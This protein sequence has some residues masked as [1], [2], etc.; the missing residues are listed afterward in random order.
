MWKKI[1]RATKNITYIAADN[2]PIQ[3]SMLMMKNTE[4]VL[5]AMKPLPPPP[6][7]NSPPFTER[8]VHPHTKLRPYL[9]VSGRRGGGWM[10]CIFLTCVFTFC[11]PPWNIRFHRTRVNANMSHV[12]E[13]LLG[14]DQ[15]HKVLRPMAP[16]V[17][18]YFSE[19]IFTSEVVWRGMRRQNNYTTGNGNSDRESDCGQ[20]YTARWYNLIITESQVN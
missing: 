18:D 6:P 7:L 9:I 5:L 8:F 13:M 4:Q 19:N 16:S 14:T 1:C 20:F 3:K 17:V 10:L 12:A 11:V 2:Q 15:I